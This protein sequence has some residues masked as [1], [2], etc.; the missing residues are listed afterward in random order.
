MKLPKSEKDFKELLQGIK[1]NRF[2][3]PLVS[4]MQPVIIGGLWLVACRFDKRADATAKFI[5]IA[6]TI[7]T[8]DLNLPKPVALASIYHTIDET[9]DVL[10]EVIDFIKDLEVPT[11]KEIIKEGKDAIIEPLEPIIE[12]AQEASHEFQTALFDC[13]ANAQD[14]LGTGWK[15]NA[16]AGPWV[17]SCMLQKGFTVPLSYVKDKL[18]I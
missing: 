17:V 13:I 1:W 18:G 15:F 4:V 14:N 16:L 6:E 12:P 7:P 11:A 3:P 2:I 9:M 10:E 5:A 8:L